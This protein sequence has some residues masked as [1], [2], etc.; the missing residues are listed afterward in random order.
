MHSPAHLTSHYSLRGSLC[1]GLDSPC[2]EFS[3]DYDSDNNLPSQVPMD[4][5]A[6]ALDMITKFTRN[7]SI[8]HVDTPPLL[9]HIVDNVFDIFAD[10]LGR[11]SGPISLA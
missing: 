7:S 11:K 9:Q 3:G 4:Q 2:Q 5:G 10:V 1:S 8:A 6:N